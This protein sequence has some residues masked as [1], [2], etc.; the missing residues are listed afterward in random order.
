ML[1]RAGTLGCSTNTSVRQKQ[2]VPARAAALL[3]LLL[4]CLLP[5]KGNTQETVVDPLIL[6]NSQVVRHQEVDYPREESFCGKFA[7]LELV[8]SAHVRV[9]RQMEI[10]FTT[11]NSALIDVTAKIKLFQKFITTEW[12]DAHKAAEKFKAPTYKQIRALPLMTQYEYVLVNAKLADVDKV[13]SNMSGRVG[14]LLS[15]H[16]DSPLLQ[17]ATLELLKMHD[18]KYQPL[19]LYG[20]ELGI[21]DRETGAVYASDVTS[22]PAADRPKFTVLKQ[23]PDGD[24][25][26]GKSPDTNEHRFLCQILQDAYLGSETSY[27]HFL[28]TAQASVALVLDFDKLTTQLREFMKNSLTPSTTGLTTWLLPLPQALT[29]VVDFLDELSEENNFLDP[30]FDM[31]HALT[32]FN[33]EMLE[34]LRALSFTPTGLLQVQ[35]PGHSLRGSALSLTDTDKL[36]D[37]VIHIDHGDGNRHQVDIAFFKKD[38]KITWFRIWPLSQLPATSRVYSD[39]FLVKNQGQTYT[40][41]SMPGLT[42]CTADSVHG[43]ICTVPGYTPNVGHDYDCGSYI[44]SGT[45]PE[46]DPCATCEPEKGAYVVAGHCGVHTPQ[47]ASGM[48]IMLVPLTVDISCPSED[49]VTVKLKA[50]EYLLPLACAVTSQGDVLYGVVSGNFQNLRANMSLVRAIQ[51]LSRLFTTEDEQ[52]DKIT[53]I[54]MAVGIPTS[55]LSIVAAVIALASKK[56]TGIFKLCRKREQGGD[57]TQSVTYT[58]THKAPAGAVIPMVQ[59]DPIRYASA[60]AYTGRGRSHRHYNADE[61]TINR[62]ALQ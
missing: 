22:I 46:V 3:L 60:P 12:N 15:A 62:L 13:C 43:Q 20:T 32:Q 1:L 27:R 5:L 45:S 29:G 39:V 61:L 36:V 47:S 55:V 48:L 53:T 35:L 19:N 59:L 49:P 38:Q 28:S 16:T 50:G 2:A 51:G 57:V 11:L 33:G 52:S 6:T 26:L 9:S 30:Q 41:S 40:A 14:E 56:C 58:A 21:Y 7:F 34:L 8:G 31:L 24:F 17:N 54:L 37:D 4:F 18:I 42:G 25:L 44:Q 10:D 23:K